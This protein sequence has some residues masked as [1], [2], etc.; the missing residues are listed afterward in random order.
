[1]S[2]L[3][4]SSIPH[5]TQD[6]TRERS[7]YERLYERDGDHHFIASGY[8]RV[9]ELTVKRLPPGATVIDVG[10]GTGQHARRF[11]QYGYEV[12]GVELAQ[13]AVDTAHAAFERLGLRGDIRCGDVRHLPFADRH[14]DAAFLSLILHH[15]RDFELVLREA[16][17]V[18]A[19]RVFVFEPNARN[20]QSYALL[21]V[22]N[23]LLRPAFLTPNQRAVSPS[24]V[25]RILLDS[26]FRLTEAHYLTVASTTKRR[27]LRQWVHAAQQL[28]PESVRHNKFIQVY[29]RDV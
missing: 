15:F 29:E 20:P 23:P 5:G 17:R 28:L 2:T 22:I 6:V 4:R 26:G 8:E 27:G 19:S 16:A 14:F 12:T 18:A 3:S 9:H 24:R 13:T 11:A 21:N 1:M 10:C 25:Q 7:H